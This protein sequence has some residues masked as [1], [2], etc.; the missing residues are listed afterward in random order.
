MDP[1]KNYIA[2]RLSHDWRENVEL[3]RLNACPSITDFSEQMNHARK[4]H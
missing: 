1:G 3:E 2:P 4:P